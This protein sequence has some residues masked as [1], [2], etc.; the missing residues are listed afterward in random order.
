MDH[1]FIRSNAISKVQIDMKH[2]HHH[3]WV[4]TLASLDAVVSVLVARA[5]PART[6]AAPLECIWRKYG[7]A[8]TIAHIRYVDPHLVDA[9]SVYRPRSGQANHKNQ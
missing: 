3:S 9:P 2:D 6:I 7:V 5:T 8:T 1:I 4:G